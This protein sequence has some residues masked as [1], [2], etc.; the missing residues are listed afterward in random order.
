MAYAAI[1]GRSAFHSSAGLGWLGDD[2]RGRG[3]GT[4]RTPLGLQAEPMWGLG[5]T[6]L[7]GGAQR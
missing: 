5:S 3:R 6:V 7:N 4:N 1:F 2:R